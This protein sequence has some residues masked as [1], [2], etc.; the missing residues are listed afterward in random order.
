MKKYMS[1]NVSNFSI[2]KKCKFNQRQTIALSATL[3]S[4]ERRVHQC[5]NRANRKQ[6][7]KGKW[8]SFSCVTSSV[9]WLNSLPY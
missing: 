8:S 7:S 3:W 1:I 4:F 2:T 6:G 5:I 9:Q